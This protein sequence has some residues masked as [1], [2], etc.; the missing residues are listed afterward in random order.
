MEQKKFRRTS[1]H[2]RPETKQKISRALRGRPKTQAHKN[3][4]RQGEF[5]YWRDD[6][7]FPDD[8]RRGE[9]QEGTTIEDLI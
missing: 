2:L 9:G 8:Q 5:R 1:R 3:A 4:I 6:N 7:N